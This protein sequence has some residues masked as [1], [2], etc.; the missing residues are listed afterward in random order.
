M[1]ADRLA[2]GNVEVLALTDQGPVDYAHSP[3]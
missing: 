2:V 1:P 3:C